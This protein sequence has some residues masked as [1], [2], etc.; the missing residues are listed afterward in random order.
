MDRRRSAAEG[1]PRRLYVY[2]GGFLTQGRVRR[3]LDLAGWDVRIGA[4]CDGDTVGVWGQSP[5]APRGEWVAGRTGAPVL[6]VEDAF[7]R[8]VLPG[9]AGG[10]PPIGLSL[11]AGGVHFDP[12]TRSDFE[13]LLATH[14]LDDAALLARARDGIAFLRRHHLSKYCAFDPDASVP[15]PGYVLVIDQ[16]EGDASVAASRA[17][18]NTFLEALFL[19][20]EEHPAARIVVKTHPETAGGHRPGHLGPDD[21]SENIDL[22]T[23]PVSPWALMEGATA[24]YTVSSQLGFEAILAGHRPVVLGQPFYAGW[25]LTDD[26]MPLDRRQRRLTR[27]Q[28]FAA[29]MILYP[30]WYD[31][32]RDRLATFEEAAAALAAEARAWR[33]DRRG[34]VASGMRLWKRKPLQQVFG[35]V[36]PVIHR[37]PPERAIAAAAAA[38]ASG[39]RLM[40]WASRETP[41]LDAAGAVRV[42]DGFL[43]SRG[44]GADLVPP[45]SLVLDD[46]G[47]YYDPTRESRLE[48]LIAASVDL[49]EGARD[50]AR[51]LVRRLTAERVTKYNLGGAALPPGLPAGRRLL[52]PGQ[53]E[54]DASIRLGTGAVSTNLALL[55]AARDAHPA[56]VILYKPHPDV[57]AGLRP[58]DVPGAAEI[59]DAVLARTDPVAALDAIDEVWTMTSAL[60]FEALLRGKR[61]VCLGRPFYAGWGLTDDRGEALPRRTA[62]PDLLGLVHAAL[63][64]YPRYF[65]PVTR[66]PCPVEVVVERLAKGQVPRPSRANRALAKAQGAL[67]SWPWLW[68]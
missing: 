29:A 15:E 9:R 58:G 47:I 53:V 17:N 65:D 44:L 36:E 28:L 22:L 11:D 18:R 25:G 20:R 56:A 60:G 57:E 34:W 41:A 8:S 54:D 10:G 45:L 42:E 62:R 59:A 2:N 49:D 5:T 50:R 35:H 48:R 52:V 14:P 23:S 6:R 32:Y 21:L 27:A 63:I 4:P 46:L 13:T 3:I 30:V 33:E 40:V 43:R 26:R 68:R 66:R 37:D 16:T 19:A 64:D 31:P 12:A 39:R 61:V 1:P 55:Q 67:S 38:A 24:V 7:L 51:A